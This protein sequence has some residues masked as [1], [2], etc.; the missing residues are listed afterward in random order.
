MR[1]VKTPANMRGYVENYFSAPTPKAL[2]I[3]QRGATYWST[4]PNDLEGA[5]KQ[6][7]A[8]CRAKTGADCT[9]AMENNVLV[10]PTTDPNTTR[11]TAH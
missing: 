10:L 1:S 7:L 9:V 8:N 2:V 5:R 11:G 6:A 3:S 4:K